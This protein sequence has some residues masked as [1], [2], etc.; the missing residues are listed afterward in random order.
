MECQ[1]KILKAVF[2]ILKEKYRDLQTLDGIKVVVN[3]DSW[4]LIRKSNTEN[5]I[6]ISTESNSLEDAKNIHLQIKELVK[7][8]HEQIKRKKDN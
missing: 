8:S 5:I 2:D 3:E 4:F 7:Q 6:R 1:E